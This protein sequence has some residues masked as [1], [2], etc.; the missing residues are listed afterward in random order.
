MTSARRPRAGRVK[1]R[2][3]LMGNTG[4]YSKTLETRETVNGVKVGTSSTA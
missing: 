4:I 3:T 2:T 1:K